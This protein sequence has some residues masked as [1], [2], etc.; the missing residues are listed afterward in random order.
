MSGDQ[1]IVLA[2][3]VGAF[4]VGWVARGDGRSRDERDGRDTRRRSALRELLEA[5]ATALDRAVVAGAAAH[6]MARADD[7]TRAVAAGVLEDAAAALGPLAERLRAELGAGHALTEEFADV[8]AA[9]GIVQDWLADGA[10][11]DGEEAARGLMRAARDALGR[12]RRIA[13]AVAAV[14]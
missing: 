5:A 7:E 8:A 14:R 9:L 2:L 1:L 3:L 12:F 6:A 10:P 13:G 11:T 4:A